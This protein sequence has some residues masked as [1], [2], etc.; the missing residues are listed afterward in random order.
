MKAN[1]ISGET[2]VSG[3]DGSFQVANKKGDISLQVNSVRSRNTHTA[4]APNG[5][6]SCAL[7][8]EVLSSNLSPP[9]YIMDLFV[10]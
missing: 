6:I 8:P 1:V 3:I 4:E 7:D 9:Y 2:T 5:S 10:D